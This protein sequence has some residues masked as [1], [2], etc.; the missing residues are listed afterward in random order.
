MFN[1]LPLLQHTYRS[2]LI[3]LKTPFSIKQT[4]KLKETC[5]KKQ[6]RMSKEIKKSMCKKCTLLMVPTITCDSYVYEKQ[7]RRLRIRCFNCEN[8]NDY[9]VGDNIVSDS[10]I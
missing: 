2:S 8:I 6:I 5:N 7:G 4:K 3:L 10:N 9:Y 1:I